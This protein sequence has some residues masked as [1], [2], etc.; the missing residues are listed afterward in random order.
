MCFG[1]LKS[2]ESA[3]AR[4]C[5]CMLWSRGTSDS[6]ILF[7]VPLHKLPPTR[8]REY[9]LI[10]SVDA[11]TCFY[12]HCGRNKSRIQTCEIPFGFGTR[13]RS[14]TCVKATSEQQRRQDSHCCSLLLTT[15]TMVNAYVILTAS[16][17]GTAYAFNASPIK[18]LAATVSVCICAG[19]LD[20]ARHF[21]KEPCCLP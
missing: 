2:K 19:K 11:P 17:I 10:G 3:I 13:S 5:G 18:M 15:A 4:S 9:L 14:D 6:R 8:Q 7:R 1:C 20:T 12:V 16:L 21:V